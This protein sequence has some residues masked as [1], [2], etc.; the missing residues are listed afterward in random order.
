MSSEPVALVTG[1]TGFIG[2]RLAQRLVE[3]G[4]AVRVLVRDA[5]RLSPGLQVSCEVAVGDLGNESGLRAATAGV[6]VVFHCAANVHTWDAWQA[7]E[8]ANVAG[9]ENLLH[10]I[11]C[12]ATPIRLVHVSSVDVYGFPLE[13]CSE[14]AAWAETEFGYGKSK[15]LGESAVRRICAEAHI[16]YTIIRPCNVI[17]PASPFI[18]RIGSELRSGLML[19]VEGGQANCGFLYVDNLIDYMI[20]AARSERAVGQTYNVRDA[21]DVSWSQFIDRFRKGI[22][23]HGLVISLPF[24][25]AD[26]LA[27]AFEWLYRILGLKGEPLLHRLIVRLFGRTCGHSADKIRSDSGMV[28][29]VGYEEAMDSSIRWF[30]ENKG[31]GSVKPEAKGGES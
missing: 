25:W 31:V 9:V 21:C 6:D 16:P 10:A 29:K 14:D 23:G 12:A 26:A 17:G 15:R 7:Y 5:S 18:T 11:A 13:P 4:W 22:H 24:A 28:G 19:K 27:G 1:A 20:W 2:G 3:L 30:L 8:Q